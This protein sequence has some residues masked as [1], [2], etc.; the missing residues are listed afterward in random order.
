MRP[1]LVALAAPALALLLA[2]SDDP[3]PTP[4]ADTP[5]TT[6]ARPA[7]EARTTPAASAAAGA[8]SS[9]PASDA[10]ASTCRP[11]A[12]LTPA[13][14]E[15]PYYKAGAP[16]RTSLIEA[17]QAGTRLL[18]RGFVL[19]ADCQP[20]AG[21]RVD[22]WQT[23]AAG[24]YDN[25]G[26]RFRGVQRT[27]ADGSYHIETVVPGE[28]PGRTP[29]IHVKVQA[30]GSPVLTTQLYFPGI[31]LNAGDGIFDPALVLRDV[32]AVATGTSARFD[33]IVRAR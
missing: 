3:A 15:G 4:A 8:A 26:F 20:L 21:A 25:A 10:L 23:D 1:A 6:T 2:C 17:G 13:Q 24:Q 5:A 9:T 16:E 32:Q 30:A 12:A 11:G 29:H 31:A 28:Y 19:T 27:A 33:F 22:V 7:S 14:A 18:V